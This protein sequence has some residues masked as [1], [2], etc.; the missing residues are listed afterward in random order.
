[1]TDPSALSISVS[2]TPAWTQTFTDNFNR[3]DGT[4]GGT[5][6]NTGN[7]AS[8]VNNQLSLSYNGGGAVERH[9]AAAEH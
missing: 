9:Y 4:I 3:A 6:I 8:I 2:G 5:W 1:L 7:E